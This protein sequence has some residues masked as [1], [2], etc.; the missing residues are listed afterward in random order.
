ML[1]ERQVLTLL[2]CVF[3]MLVPGWARGKL[4]VLTNDSE[5]RQYHLDRH[6]AMALEVTYTS[7]DFAGIFPLDAFDMGAGNILR[8]SGQSQTQ[9]ERLLYN[10]FSNR[11]ETYKGSPRKGVKILE[12]ARPEDDYREAAGTKYRDIF[13]LEGHF[14]GLAPEGVDRL[15]KSGESVTSKS[16]LSFGGSR[17]RAAAVSPWGEAFIS[18]TAGN[19]ILRARLRGVKLVSNGEISNENLDSPGELV[20]NARGE[21]FVAARTGVLRFDFRPSRG[22]DIQDLSWKD[23]WRASFKDRLDVG[24]TGA[25]DVTLALPFGV[26]V[27]EKTKPIVRLSRE[28]AG[29]HHGISQSIFLYP[30]DVPD[31]ILTNSE[32]AVV[33]LVQY[34][35]GGHTV[36]HAHSDTEQAFFVLEGRA[37]F[38]VGEIEVETG[39]GD[40]VMANRH[41]KHGY[42]VLGD[43]PLKFMQIEWVGIE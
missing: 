20:F 14:F 25:L 11:L 3:L 4:F 38:Q 37:I 27:S 13:G 42:R 32:A 26:V 43:K 29:D 33:A 28:K 18:D 31:E 7:E 30:N 16:E 36:I 39:P 41:V 17:L 19:R 9:K 15:E 34:D 35:P 21:L 8:C 5:I 6:G 22:I 1:L 12:E 2:L 10:Q 23:N 40:L 24:K